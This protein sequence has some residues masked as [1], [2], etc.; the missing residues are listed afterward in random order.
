MDEARATAAVDLV[1]RAAR[2]DRARVHGRARRRPRALAPAARAR[3]VHD[4]GRLHRPRRGRRAPTTTTS[5]RRR[6]RRSARRCGRPSRA[7]DG[8]IRST[9]GHRVN[10]P[11]KVVLADY[12]A[13]N[14]RSVTSA[15][16]A[17]R[18]RARRS[19]PTPTP[20]REAPLAVIAGVGHVESAARGLAAHGLD[21]AIRERVAAGRPVLGICVGMQL[22]FGES[23]EGGSGPRPPRRARAPRA[24]ARACRTWAGTTSRVDAAVGARRRPR[25]R[26]RLLRPQLRR[27]ARRRRRRRRRRRS[28]RPRRRRR[29]ARGRRRRPVPPRAQR[30]LPAPASSRT[31]WHGQEAR[32]PL[33]RRRRTAASSRAS[34]SSTSG[35]WASRSS[36]PRA[37]RSSEPTSSSS[38]TS[39]RRSRAAARS[40]S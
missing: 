2:R 24:R 30:A 8:G 6:S 20:S 13:G 27:R 15:L 40:S 32:D 14:L 16:R 19:R 9:K 29:R 21:D 1:R 23:E 17:G 36:S 25:R 35:R 37:T 26:G 39:P 5:P 3:A 7:G 22:L 12:G 33:P 18:R 38:S 28:R 34:T 11:V 4:G 31:R 10:A